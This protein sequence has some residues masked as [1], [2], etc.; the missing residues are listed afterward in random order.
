MSRKEG[1]RNGTEYDDCV[2]GITDLAD[3]SDPEQ[4]EGHEDGCSDK[5][6]HANKTGQPDKRSNGYSGRGAVDAGIDQ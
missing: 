4:S 5:R 1:V 3:R 6:S 2:G